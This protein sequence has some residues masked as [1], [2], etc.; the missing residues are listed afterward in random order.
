MLAYLPDLQ[1]YQLPDPGQ[2]PAST[3][4]EGVSQN[5]DLNQVAI[6]AYNIII[7]T[8]FVLAMINN[9]NVW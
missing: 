1:D 2:L 5:R 7:H 6:I 4:L 8:L 3:K 9:K